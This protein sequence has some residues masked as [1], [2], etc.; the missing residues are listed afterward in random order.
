M[1]RCAINTDRKTEELE[2]K[3][4]LY[5]RKGKAIPVQAPHHRNIVHNAARKIMAVKI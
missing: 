4:V 5:T 1:E 3:P 2:E